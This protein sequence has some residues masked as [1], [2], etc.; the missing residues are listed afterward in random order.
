MMGTLLTEVYD[1]NKGSGWSDVLMGQ[2]E[3][4]M[5]EVTGSKGKKVLKLEDKNGEKNRGSLTLSYRIMEEAERQEGIRKKKE[6]ARKRKEAD[7]ALR[8]QKMWLTLT[9]ERA[10]NL[11]DI[12]EMLGTG[13][14]DPYVVSKCKKADGTEAHVDGGKEPKTS[15]KDGNLNPEYGESFTYEIDALQLKQGEE[16][17][18]ME[19]EVWDSNNT[20]DSSMGRCMVPLSRWAEGIKNASLELVKTDSTAGACGTVTV[21]VTVVS[22]ADREKQW[23]IAKDREDKRKAELERLRREK[24]CLTV[25][26]VKANNLKNLEITSTSDPFVRISVVESDGSVGEGHTKDTVYKDG[27]LDPVW[28]EFVEFDLS[29]A[30]LEQG[31]YESKLSLIV[32]DYNTISHDIMG[33]YTASSR[34]F[35]SLAHSSAPSQL[36]T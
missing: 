24:S 14:S 11:V 34:F 4:K 12:E 9:I 31:E 27:C 18:K 26:A 1:S 2:A 6:E 17:S 10:S 16:E 22:D 15:V 33:S 28:N 8:K 7:E 13:V 23:R 5:T 29:S 19:I 32:Y 25:T 36:T 35:S 20:S 30:Q 3:L 21:S